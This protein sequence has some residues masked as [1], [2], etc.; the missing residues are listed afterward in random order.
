MIRLFATFAILL[1]AALELADVVYNKIEMALYYNAVGA[2][3][4]SQH[5]GTFELLDDEIENLHERDLEDA[6]VALRYR[7]KN[8]V[9]LTKREDIELPEEGLTIVDSGST[10]L[11]DLGY[12]SSAHRF[13]THPGYVWSYTIATSR[14]ERRIAE[15]FGPLSL[16]KEQL[17]G[18]DEH[19]RAVTMVRLRSFY[20]M[21]LAVKKIADLNLS[22]RDKAALSGSQV[23]IKH[24]TES[25]ELFMIQ[26]DDE[27]IFQLGPI[28]YPD[29]F[30]F[31]DWLLFLTLLFILFG[32][33]FIWVWALWRDL[34]RLRTASLAV[35]AGKLDT[36]VRSRSYSL[37]RPVMDGFNVMAK[38]T[39]NMVES[40]REL[41]NAVSHELRTPLA[42][43]MFDLQMAKDAVNK[44]DQLRHFESLEYNVAELNTLVDELLTYAR[45]ERLESPVELETFTAEEMHDWL[46][47]Q[48]SRAHHGR[49][50]AIDIATQ[51]D[52]T[53]SVEHSIQ[54]CPRLFAHALSNTLQNA[55]RFA[56]KR[57]H[58]QLQQQQNSWVLSVEDDGMGIP[59][60]RWERV[61]EPF[62][63]LDESRQ[64][65][66]G[67]YGL[68]LAIV[69]KIAHWHH[70]SAGLTHSE[71]LSGTR[72]EIRWPVDIHYTQSDNIDPIQ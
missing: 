33:T 65:D 54:I 52:S 14:A 35:G 67:G 39:E 31:T 55:L 30:D 64:R 19:Q 9:Q 45:Q 7:F 25:G 40:Q 38:R 26:L 69:R 1:F 42:R 51:F 43:L 41:T 34:K 49:E 6:V 70:G 53:S 48:V 18:N 68:G 46:L 3:Y 17:V 4:A 8:S 29:S 47:S 32:A 37:I 60:E 27:L 10:Y 58:V 21:P 62:S 44:D 57:I 5:R 15:F 23:I 61:F 20:D 12:A 71:R 22:D 66:S 56:N 2:F 72:V 24:V 13:S 59:E 16:I 63:R 36:R 11:Y 28:E 50:D